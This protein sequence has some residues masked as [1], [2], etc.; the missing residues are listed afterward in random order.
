[1]NDEQRGMARLQA[2]PEGSG[3]FFRNPALALACV[4]QLHGTRVA[5]SCEKMA[6]VATILL[7]LADPNGYRRLSGEFR[8]HH[9]GPYRSGGEGISPL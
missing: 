3:P 4:A 7:V 8:P 2:Q 6:A 5:L 9:Q 1:M